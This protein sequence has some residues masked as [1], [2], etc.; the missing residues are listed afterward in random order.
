MKKFK[1]IS[2]CLMLLVL[3]TFTACEEEEIMTYDT[4]TRASVYFIGSSVEYSFLTN[5]TDEYVIEVS[6]RLMGDTVNY[7]RTFNVEVIPDLTTASD[8]QYEIV[9]GIV[10]AGEFEGKLYVRVFKSDALND[11]MAEIGLRI[12][13]SNDLTAGNIQKNEYLIGFTNKIVLPPLQYF[14]YF[15]CKAKSTECYRIFVLT[16][17]LTDFGRTEYMAYGSS[18]TQAI[19]TKF[20][21][22]IMEW[23]KNHPDN[24]L[25]HDDGT[26]AGEDIV[27]LYYTHSKYD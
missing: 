21:D 7:D 17:G 13:D 5:P 11:T 23:N 25:K 27:P 1:Y 3:A 9:E 10:K 14:K 12:V 16:T 6:V 4:T 2:F 18:G 20:G 19:A 15:F 22:Y 26:S 8:N 24:H